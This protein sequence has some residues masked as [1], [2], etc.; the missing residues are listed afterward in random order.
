MEDLDEPSFDFMKLLPELQV[1]VFE[2]L[3]SPLAAIDLRLTCRDL[4]ALF[5]EYK[6]QIVAA[7]RDNMVAPF[8]EYYTFHGRLHIP[9]SDI[10]HPPAGGWPNITLENCS[11]FGKSDFAVDVLRHLP[12]IVEDDQRRM[13]SLNIHNIDYKSYV[14]DY[15]MVTRQCFGCVGRVKKDI[16]YGELMHDHVTKHKVVISEGYQSGGIVLLLDTSTGEIFEEIVRDGPGETLPVRDYFALKM[17]Q[18]KEL[19]LVFVPGEDPHQS[20][21]DEVEPPYDA[22]AMEEAGEPSSPEQYFFFAEDKDVEWVRHLYRKFGWPGKS[23]QKEECLKAIAEFRDRREA[24]YAKWKAEME[25][26]RAEVLARLGPT[27]TVLNAL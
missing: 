6:T 9:E 22:A 15:S 25:R 8:Y 13:N 14:L 11:G 26:K 27:V 23:W 5:V 2:A 4:N 24:E 17:R 16:K 10:K 21:H 19:R 20:D 3:P 1:K 7:I 12:Y 18:C